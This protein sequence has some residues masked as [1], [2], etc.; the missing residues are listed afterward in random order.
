MV[1]K[2]IR[3]SPIRWLLVVA[4]V[5]LSAVLTSA[6]ASTARASASSKPYFIGVTGF[7]TGPI[8][9]QFLQSLEGFEAYIDHVNATGGVNGR[10]IHVDV[11]NDQGNPTTAELDYRTFVGDGA[12][13]IFADTISQAFS[14]LFPA[15]AQ[16]KIPTFVFSLFG[17]GAQPY[18]YGVDMQTAASVELEAAFLHNSLA[19]GTSQKLAL[20][21]NGDVTATPELTELQNYDTKVGWSVVSQ[22][23]LPIGSV[24]FGPQAASIAQSSPTAIIMALDSVSGPAAQS[25]MQAVGVNV[26]IVN[27]FVCSQADIQAF[28]NPNFYCYQDFADPNN[29]ALAKDP[30]VVSLLSDMKAAHYKLTAPGG[31]DI[32]GDYLVADILVAALKKCGAS[33]TSQKLNTEIQSPVSAVKTGGLAVSVG[34]TKSNHNMVHKVQ[35]YRWEQKTNGLISVGAPVPVPTT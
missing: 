16:N 28:K 24:A 21:T 9:A 5:A 29:K 3:T 31:S 8:G 11:V 34:F 1:G 14:P 32:S 33:C 7:F 20:I 10:K 19:N 17:P 12:I 15:A 22:Q 2:L 26:P 27:W 25:A 23:V 30:G 35:F 13:A 4:L 6:T 18:V